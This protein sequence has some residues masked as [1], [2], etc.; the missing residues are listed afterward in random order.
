MLG[1]HDVFR[2]NSGELFGPMVLQVHQVL[3]SLSPVSGCQYASDLVDWFAVDDARRRRWFGGLNEG[4][5][6][7]Q[8]HLAYV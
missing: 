4:G 1:V 2:W 7:Y 6:F 8:F 5:L 3:Q